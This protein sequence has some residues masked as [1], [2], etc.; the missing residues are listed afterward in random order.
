MIA[1]INITDLILAGLTPNEFVYLQRLKENFA[2]PSTWLDSID[3]KKLEESGFIKIT[4]S[5]CI[6]RDKSLHLF[7]D[8]SENLE[9]FVERY[10]NLFPLGTKEGYPFRGDKV[11]C[12][13]KMERFIKNYPNTTKEEIIEATKAYVES[14]NKKMSGNTYMK[15]AHYFIDKNGVSDLAAHIEFLKGRG[16]IREQQTTGKTFL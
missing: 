9:D 1:V 3:T 16:E 14:F 10:R 2:V 6:L 7:K 5:G 8:K 11:G 4:E 12:R 15:Q 13:K